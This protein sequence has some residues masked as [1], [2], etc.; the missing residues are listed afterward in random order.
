MCFATLFPLGILQLYESVGDGYFEARDLKF[1]TNDTNSLLEWLRLPGDVLFIVGGAI[2]VLYIAY[3]G[4]RHRVKRTTL[5]EPDDILFVDMAEP[6]GVS[7]TT[8]EEASAART[9]R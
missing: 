6:A 1:L 3:V 4:I 7:G 9:G 5:E 2:P 8:A